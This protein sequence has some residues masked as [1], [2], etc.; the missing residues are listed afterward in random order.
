MSDDEITKGGMQALLQFHCMPEQ[1]A[2]SLVRHQLKLLSAE[3]DILRQLEKHA[4][5]N[6]SVAAAAEKHIWAKSL[7]E[8][9]EV[10][11]FFIIIDFFLNLKVLLRTHQFAQCIQ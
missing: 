6:Q 7:Q 10:L 8:E 3:S 9:R 4:A 11:T 5:T 2:G 1:S